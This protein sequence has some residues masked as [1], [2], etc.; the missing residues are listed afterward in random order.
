MPIN[1]YPCP[2]TRFRDCFFYPDPP[3]ETLRHWYNVLKYEFEHF[4]TRL[5]SHKALVVFDQNFT[6]ELVEGTLSNR[7]EYFAQ[8]ANAFFPDKCSEEY[9]EVESPGF[10]ALRRAAAKAYKDWNVISL[11]QLRDEIDGQRY[12]NYL[13]HT[14]MEIACDTGLNEI[15]YNLAAY[16]EEEE[17]FSRLLLGEVALCGAAEAVAGAYEA[18]DIRVINPDTRQAEKDHQHYPDNL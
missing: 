7:P 4:D 8:V 9:L 17:P 12:V 6:P 15:A 13:N 5:T 16:L 10:Q 14:V 18:C 2:Y 1:E 11:G 3:V